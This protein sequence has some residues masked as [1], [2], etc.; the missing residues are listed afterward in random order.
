MWKLSSKFYGTLK[1]A[2]IHNFSVTEHF[3][4]R[5]ESQIL[6]ILNLETRYVFFQFSLTDLIKNVRGNCLFLKPS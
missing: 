1:T 5:R 2:I 4:L 3:T 6:Q